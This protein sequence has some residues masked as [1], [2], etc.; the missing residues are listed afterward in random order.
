MPNWVNRVKHKYTLAD[1]AAKPLKVML[2]GSG[3]SFNPDHDYVSSANST[4][5][6][7]RGTRADTAGLDAS[8]W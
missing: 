3:Y 6:R 5:S 4:N 8:P 1:L 2:M 7:C